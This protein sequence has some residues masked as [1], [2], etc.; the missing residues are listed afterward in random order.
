MLY[1]ISSLFLRKKKVN[2]F[3]IMLDLQTSLWAFILK[4]DLNVCTYLRQLSFSQKPYK[5]YDSNKKNRE[6]FYVYWFYQVPTKSV[7]VIRNINAGK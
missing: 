5:F 1:I 7:I 6:N 4:N 2:A 3:D